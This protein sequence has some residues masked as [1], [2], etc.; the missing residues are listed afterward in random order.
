LTYYNLDTEN[1]KTF[2]RNYTYDEL[3]TFVSDTIEEYL[4]YTREDVKWK[5]ER[6]ESLKVLP[7]P[8]MSY[9][10]GQRD[11]A[12]DVYRTLRQGGK[13]FAKAPTG[14]GKTISTLF[15]AIK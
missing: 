1:T 3:K 9:R 2:E 14:I 11:L 4:K 7:F 5:K 12:V 10:L 8:F 6:N 15:P 13:L